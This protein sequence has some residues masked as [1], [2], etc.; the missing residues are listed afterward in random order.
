M[1][2][3]HRTG[4]LAVLR[5][6]GALTFVGRVGDQVR[7]RCC[8]HGVRH[9]GG[10][11]PAAPQAEDTEAS[12]LAACLRLLDQPGLTSADDLTDSGETSP[13]VARLVALIESTRPIRVRVRRSCAGPTWRPSPRW[14][15][16]AGRSPGTR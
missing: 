10:A 1:P 3:L 15:P 8:S 5:A 9:R 13:A 14:R 2:W 6:D 12:L 11:D 4:D 7:I 16:H